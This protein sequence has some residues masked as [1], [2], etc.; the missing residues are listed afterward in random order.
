MVRIRE[1]LIWGLK[2]GW[3]YGAFVLAISAVSLLFSRREAVASSGGVGTVL[4]ALA[5]IYAAGGT[6]GGLLAA[7]LRPLMKWRIGAAITGATIALTLGTAYQL[8]DIGF[9]LSWTDIFAT[10]TTA[11]VVGGGAGA[12]LW[13]ALTARV[14]KSSAPKEPHT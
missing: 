4:L 1:N 12:I 6:I 3:L 8:A 2:R 9:H 14:R 10:V 13:T 11:I 7:F 5:G